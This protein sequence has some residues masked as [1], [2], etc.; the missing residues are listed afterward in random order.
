MPPGIN[1][2][3]HILLFTLDKLKS[4]PLKVHSWVNLLSMN[5]PNL[6]G[7]FPC[8]WP[9]SLCKDRPEGRRLPHQPSVAEFISS[10]AEDQ[11]AGAGHVTTSDGDPCKVQSHLVDPNP[12]KCRECKAYWLQVRWNAICMPPARFNDHSSHPLLSRALTTH[13]PKTSTDLC[14]STDELFDGQMQLS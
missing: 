5:N 2:L 7:Q 12:R 9:S 14:H 13:R 6:S 4:L 3:S 10:L 11:N 8:C 1:H